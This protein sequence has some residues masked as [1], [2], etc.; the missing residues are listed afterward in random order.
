MPAT[1]TPNKLIMY[2]FLP[3]DNIAHLYFSFAEIH[4]GVDCS[5]MLLTTVHI[6][7]PSR[8]FIEDC[9]LLI[10]KLLF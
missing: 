7:V 6:E 4:C 3:L 9:P 1:N 8:N 10:S 5:G 2:Q